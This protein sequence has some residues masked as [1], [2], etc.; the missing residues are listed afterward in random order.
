MTLDTG[1]QPPAIRH[2]RP[3]LKQLGTAILVRLG[4]QPEATHL[5]LDS[6]RVGLGPGRTSRRS[7]HASRTEDIPALPAGSIG[8]TRDFEGIINR[9][10]DVTGE[11]EVVA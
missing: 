7:F 9:T 2:P 11:V 8:S 3:E 1:N 5:T 10:F 4:T 6:R